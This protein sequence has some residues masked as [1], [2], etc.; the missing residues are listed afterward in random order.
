MNSTEEL[1]QLSS[2]IRDFTPEQLGE[3]LK[4]R[5]RTSSTEQSTFLGLL[6]YRLKPSWASPVLFFAAI[7]V[8]IVKFSMLIWFYVFWGKHVLPN[9]DGQPLVKAANVVFPIG[10]FILFGTQLWSTYVVWKIANQA[11]QN[12][13]QQNGNEKKLEEG[14]ASN[15]ASTIRVDEPDQNA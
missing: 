3:V 11:R 10:G 12:Q 7:Q 1:S 14:S 6:F 2:S 9:E 13:N 4:L 5:N 8:F 15:R